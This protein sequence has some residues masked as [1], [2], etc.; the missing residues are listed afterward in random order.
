[1]AFSQNKVTG[2]G[3]TEG[4]IRS[5]DKPGVEV[6]VAV[7]LGVEVAVGD[8]VSVGVSVPTGVGVS[9]G[10]ETSVSVEVHVGLGV[11]VADAATR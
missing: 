7:A 5:P 4:S 9:V 3:R 2:P 8:G 11:G 10:E 6:T 1:M